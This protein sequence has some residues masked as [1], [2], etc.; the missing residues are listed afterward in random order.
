MPVLVDHQPATRCLF[1]ISAAT[2]HPSSP[3]NAVISSLHGSW[4]RT[5]PRMRFLRH[6]TLAK[7]VISTQYS[8]RSSLRPQIAISPAT[9]TLGTC[10]CCELVS[11]SLWLAVVVV[12]DAA[13]CR[14]LPASSSLSTRC[15]CC[16]LDSARRRAASHNDHPPR[17]RHEIIKK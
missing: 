13:A 10:L 16:D 5:G 14:K 3:A 7:A 4:R 6:L 12:T 2:G 1:A 15:Q 8:S 17:W 9:T 11:V